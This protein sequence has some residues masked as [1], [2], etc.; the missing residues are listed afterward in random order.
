MNLK[1]LITKYLPQIIQYISNWLGK[2]AP[3][4]SVP[5]TIITLN[6][7]RIEVGSNGIF[8][9]LSE[10][11][12][13]I[14]YT[15]EHA[16]DSL[17]KVANGTYTVK[18]GFHQLETDPAPRKLYQIMNVVGH[19]NILLHNGNFPQKDSDGCLLLGASIADYQ[20][21]R[22]VT[23]SVTTLNNFMQLMEEIESFTL[24]IS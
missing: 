22:I 18:L 7:K 1:D 11:G 13:I 3:Q 19:S 2:Q 24:I 23:D 21:Q 20:G 4:A 6:L 9:E 17:P 8:S 15:A 16:Y 5:N 12:K 10:D 14:C